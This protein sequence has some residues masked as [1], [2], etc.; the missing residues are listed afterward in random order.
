[1]KAT[2]PFT[3]SPSTNRIVDSLRSKGWL[4]EPFNA[5]KVLPGDLVFFGQRITGEGMRWYH[6]E[7]VYAVDSKTICTI[8]GNVGELAT[9]MV[10][11]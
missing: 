1:M 4:I 9:G 10:T 8:G 2:L 11:E 7:I 3:D 5:S 6:T